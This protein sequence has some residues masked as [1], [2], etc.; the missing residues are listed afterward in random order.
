MITMRQ[1]A[2]ALIFLPLPLAAQQFE[3]E[4]LRGA[5]IGMFGSNPSQTKL[6]CDVTCRYWKLDKTADYLRCSVMLPPDAPRRK[7]CEWNFGNAAEIIEAGHGC[8][9]A[10]SYD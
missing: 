7:L 9:P 1:I 6:I 2:I 3:C 5:G 10:P 8:K 4:L